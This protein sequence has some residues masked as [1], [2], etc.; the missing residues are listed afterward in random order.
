MFPFPC[1]SDHV[2]FPLLT[3]FLAFCLWFLLSFL[4]YREAILSVFYLAFKFVGN[5]MIKKSS[6]LRPK[7]HVRITITL[8]VSFIVVPS[9][10]RSILPDLAFLSST[11]LSFL[12]LLHSLLRLPPSA[13]ILHVNHKYLACYIKNG[14]QLQMLME[15]ISN[16]FFA[17]YTSPL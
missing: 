11:F 6:A 8:S 14:V 2:C 3:I 10:S 4:A 1:F 7:L 16:P 13:L 17:D 12:I 15:A 5:D 9:L